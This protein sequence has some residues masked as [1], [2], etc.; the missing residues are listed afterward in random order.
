MLDTET[1]GYIHR[2]LRNALG[3]P[4]DELT[5]APFI[6]SRNRHI[7][8]LQYQCRH[9]AP[10]KL[11]LILNV[12]PKRPLLT[13][14]NAVRP[15]VTLRQLRKLNYLWAS[16]SLRCLQVGKLGKENF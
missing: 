14:M 6:I 3:P 5:T 15:R 2:R 16:H 10:T 8:R 12:P 11:L 4:P 7:N 13:E 9:T 1:L